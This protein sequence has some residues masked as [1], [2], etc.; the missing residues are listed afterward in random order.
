ML[1]LQLPLVGLGVVIGGVGN[2]LINKLML[3]EVA[4]GACLRELP[5]L[6]IIETLIIIRIR[7]CQ[8]LSHLGQLY[9]TTGRSWCMSRVDLLGLGCCGAR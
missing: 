6:V 4:S 3:A 8:A 7:S 2:F 5:L 1:L 9:H